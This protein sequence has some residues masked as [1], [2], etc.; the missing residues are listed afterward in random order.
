MDK[1]NKIELIISTFNKVRDVIRIN[2]I[3][4]SNYADL[5]D[6]DLQEAQELLIKIIKE[7]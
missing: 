6:D 1:D 3:N 7:Q 4:N 5:I 2:N